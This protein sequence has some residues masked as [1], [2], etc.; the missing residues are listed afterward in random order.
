MKL[1][2][3]VQGVT[4]PLAGDTMQGDKLGVREAVTERKNGSKRQRVTVNAMRQTVGT[5]SWTGPH[6]ILPAT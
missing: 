3:G 6:L 1:K 5:S 2:L 4:P